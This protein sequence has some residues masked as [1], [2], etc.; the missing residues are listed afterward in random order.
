[1]NDWGFPIDGP[2]QWP[3]L[4]RASGNIK[5]NAEKKVPAAAAW[6][7]PTESASSPPRSLRE[8]NCCTHCRVREK[9]NLIPGRSRFFIGRHAHWEEKGDG[10][11]LADPKGYFPLEQTATPA[12]S[13]GTWAKYVSQIKRS[14]YVDYCIETS[15]YF[16]SINLKVMAS[17]WLVL[18]I[19]AAGAP[20]PFLVRELIPQAQVV[21]CDQSKQ[22]NKQKHI[23]IMELK[24]SYRR[25]K[26]CFKCVVPLRKF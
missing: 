2:E 26:S 11:G 5:G 24:N 1:M 8:R 22:T 19:F 6:P 15:K 4:C 20:V 12:W 3:R 21:W 25:N 10:D 9:N 16:T 7:L 13:S 17:Q 23:K 18:L 14:F